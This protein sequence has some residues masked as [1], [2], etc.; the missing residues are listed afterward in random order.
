MTEII[1]AFSLWQPWGSLWLSP[2][3]RRETR[4]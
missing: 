2:N 4:H 3:K 1:K